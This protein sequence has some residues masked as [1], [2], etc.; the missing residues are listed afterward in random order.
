MWPRMPY[1]CQRSAVNLKIS[2]PKPSCFRI[3]YLKRIRVRSL[4]K[5]SKNN[6]NHELAMVGWEWISKKNQ[7]SGFSGFP[8][9]SF[10][11]VEAQGRS[12][13]SS[14][15]KKDK[16]ATFLSTA[17]ILVLSQSKAICWSKRVSDYGIMRQDLWIGIICRQIDTVDNSS[18]GLY[19]LYRVVEAVI[20]LPATCIN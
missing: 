17:L 9:L 16:P 7:A 1:K 8:T 15:Q 3:G 11:L 12:S 13:Q 6:L 4:E 5:R 18:T 14:K 20:L 2:L 19:R 10:S